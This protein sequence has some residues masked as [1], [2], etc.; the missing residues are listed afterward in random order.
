WD[1]M[2]R[3]F[4]QHGW[5]GE[6]YVRYFDHL[7]TPIGSSRAEKGRIWINSNTWAVL[8]GFASADRAQTALDSVDRH[9]NTKYGLKLSAPGYDGF[10]RE[11]GGVTTYPPGAKENGGIFL[12]TNPWAIIA[13]TLLGDGDRAFRYYT[14]INPAAK[15]D[16]IE[17]YEAEPYCYPQNIL[18]DEHPQFGLARNTWLS[19]TSSWTYVAATQ[20]ILGLRPEVDGLRIDPC[21]PSDWPGFTAVR[22]FRGATYRVEVTKPLGICRGVKSVTVDGTVL[23][24]NLV[25]VLAAGTHEVRVVMG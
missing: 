11:I 25:P 15:N 4:E 12:H 10:D 1:Q 9:L 14:Q 17:M 7:G 6:W 2:R 21:L 3:A 23:G 19:G 22:K 24:A 20:H 18:G 5:D 8:S 16:L 13:N